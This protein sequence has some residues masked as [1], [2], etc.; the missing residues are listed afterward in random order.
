MII[1]ER[2]KRR[3]IDLFKQDKTL[4][5]RFHIITPA[6]HAYESRLAYQ[7]LISN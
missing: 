4:K 3:K 2:E 1:R 6:Y 5:V 7:T